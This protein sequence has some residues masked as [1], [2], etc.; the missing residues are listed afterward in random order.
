MLQFNNGILR[1]KQIV[2]GN[3]NIIKFMW[4]FTI[5][6]FTFTPRSVQDL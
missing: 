1:L 3:I 5:A 2:G 6:S 4:H